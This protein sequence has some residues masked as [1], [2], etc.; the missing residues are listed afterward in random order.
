MR[1]LTRRREITCPVY[2]NESAQSAQ[3]VE[4]LQTVLH[5]TDQKRPSIV[6]ERDQFAVP[7]GLLYVTSNVSFMFLNNFICKL[8]QILFIDELVRCV[9]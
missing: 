8:L 5:H 4:T 7:F 3:S 2:Y 6:Y 9:L 1:P